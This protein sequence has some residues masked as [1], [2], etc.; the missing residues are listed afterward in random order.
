MLNSKLIIIKK[1]VAIMRNSTIL[2]ILAFNLLIFTLL[3]IAMLFGKVD[4]I[5]NKMFELM[6]YII[7]DGLTRILIYITN[8][9]YVIIPVCLILLVIP[10]TRTISIPVVLTMIV[11]PV[12][13]KLLKSSFG[14]LRPDI[15]SMV[16]A[17]GYS[18]P[19][20]HTTNTMAFYTSIAIIALKYIENKTIKITVVICSYILAITTGLSRIY[21]GVHYASD[22]LAGFVL[23]LFISILIF[24]I[25][26]N[27]LY[28]K[29]SKIFFL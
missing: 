13:V 14:R 10:K 29:L 16:I 4:F 12:C 24:F 15:E 1:E 5:D 20:G 17:T 7:A 11:S 22:V 2:L 27:Y 28:N 23:G 19:S 8:F 26:D 18:F 3:S 6:N 25:W 21:L 9:A